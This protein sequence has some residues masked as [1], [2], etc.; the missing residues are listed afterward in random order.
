MQALICSDFG[1]PETLAVTEIDIPQPS[2]GDVLIKVIAAGLSFVDVMICRNLH[3][4]KHE[5]PFSPGKEI[6]G[7]IMAL[8]KSVEGFKVGDRVAALVSDGGHAEYAVAKPSEVFLLPENCDPVQTAAVLSVAL[9]S[10]VAL[11]VKGRVQRGE[12]VLVGGGAGGVGLTAIQLA[13]Y[14]GAR[15]IAAVSTAERAEACKA[16]GADA[17]VIYSPNLRDDVRAAN[18]G[19]DMDIILD[20]VGG[21]FAEQAANCLDWDGRYLVIGFAGGGIPTFAANRLLVKNRSVHGVILGFYRWQ[22]PD[23]LKEMAAVVLGAIEKGALNVPIVHI[24]DLADVP[25]ALAQIEN[26]QMIGKA[27][28]TFA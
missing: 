5:L 20:P 21:A 22:K 18:D 26:R 17:A 1:G 3:Q 10:Q 24:D 9:T 16:A 15:V 23:I 25:A 7:K 28:V 12:T 13:K 11:Q 19:R 8:G 6:T 4:N 2:D 14:H 27:V